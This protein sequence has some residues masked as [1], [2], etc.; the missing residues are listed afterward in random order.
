MDRVFIMGNGG[1]GKTWLAQQLAQR[2]RYPVFHLDVFHWLP[3]VDGERPR[4][5]RNRLVAEAAGCNSWIMEG[6][7]TARY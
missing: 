4:D 5:E 3:N 6:A 7:S 1:S 2:L